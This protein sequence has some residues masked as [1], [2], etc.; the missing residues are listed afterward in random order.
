[1]CGILFLIRY[2]A[3]ID[4]DI[5]QK[6]LNKLYP[7]GPDRERYMLTETN[8]GYFIYTGFRRLCIMDI[9]D[10]GLQPF[11]HGSKHIVCNGEIYNYQFLAKNYSIDMESKCDCEVLLP[12]YEK[13]GFD[14]MIDELDAEFALILYDGDRRTV[15]IAR[16][17]F[18]VR[19]LF[20]GYNRTTQTI[21][22]ASELKALHDICEFVSPLQP[23]MMIKLDLNKPPVT[24]IDELLTF[25]EYYNFDTNMTAVTSLYDFI[26][27]QDQIIDLFT[28]SV[29]KRLQADRPIGFLLSGGLDS[30]LVVSVA[31]RILGPDAITCFSIGLAGSPDVEAAKTVC[32]YLGITKHHIIPFD[33]EL[34][35]QELRNVIETLE[36]Y[37]ITTIRA[38]TP[39]YLMAKYISENTDIKVILSGEGSDEIAAGYRYN[40]NAPSPAELHWEAVRLVKDLYL[41]DN[42]RTDRTMSHHGLEVRVPFLDTEFVHFIMRI[43][44][45]LFMHTTESMEKQ[46]IRDSFAGYL[47]D[48]ILYRRKEAFSDAV[49][50]NEINWYKSIISKV[51]NIISDEELANNPFSFNKPE[52]KDA[53]YFRRIFHDV[54]SGRDNVL[55]Y[56]WLPRFQE[57][58]ITD[59]S[60][61]ILKCYP[62]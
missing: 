32:Q 44:P 59:P 50:S 49:S 1:M 33:V 18:G 15:N 13:V 54:Y 51:D 61:T 27:I 10:A 37:D 41:F 56:Y 11:R 39:Q 40:Y 62:Q 12:L 58:K 53:L 2:G 57:E 4:S 21:G 17:K 28:E 52:T 14:I 47:P 43:N 24:N 45:L 35:F 3:T 16:D 36:S 34:G 19:P 55:P 7:R 25:N 20:Y 31:T 48:E 46:I 6:C 30:S 22:F 38:S 29:H 5:S 60:A 26:Y 42:L 9:T 8:T 23:N